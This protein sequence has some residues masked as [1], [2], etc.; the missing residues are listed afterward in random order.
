M[1]YF[2]SPLTLSWVLQ[3]LDLLARRDDLEC[4]PSNRAAR[5]SKRF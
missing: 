1:S 2:R 4:A 3:T 5:V